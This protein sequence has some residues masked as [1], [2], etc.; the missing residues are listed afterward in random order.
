[1][2]EIGMTSPDVDPARMTPFLR[3]KSGCVCIDQDRC[4]AMQL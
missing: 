4:R 3:H 1:M 2:T